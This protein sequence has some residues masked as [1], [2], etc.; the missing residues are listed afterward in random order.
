MTKQKSLANEEPPTHH[1]GT[2]ALE[3]AEAKQA[4]AEFEWHLG[5]VTRMGHFEIAG[6]R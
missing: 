2:E 5:R 6:G 4:G 1:S 3:A